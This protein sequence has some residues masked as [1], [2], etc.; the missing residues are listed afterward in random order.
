L[1]WLSESFLGVVRL[2]LSNRTHSAN[3]S[4]CFFSRGDDDDAQSKYTAFLARAQDAAI[5]F[6][7]TS[8]G[9]RMIVPKLLIVGP[10]GK[11]SFNQISLAAALVDAQ[12]ANANFQGLDDA[13][14]RT[15]IGKWRMI[16][17]AIGAGIMT[18]KQIVEMTIAGTDTQCYTVGGNQNFFQIAFKSLAADPAVADLEDG[19]FS[20]FKNTVSGNV[21]AAVNDGGVIKKV[22]LV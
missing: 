20:V 7:S 16:T 21:W 12:I 14:S 8:G 9:P 5:T 19:F 18:L 15:V 6:S 17:Q 11:G 10:D 2:F 3:N 13:G 1:S 22:Q 4:A